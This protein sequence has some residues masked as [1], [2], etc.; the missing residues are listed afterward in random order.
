[1]ARV[2][3]HERT[4]PAGRSTS[5]RWVRK[6]PDAAAIDDAA[7]VACQ[8]AAGA[9][10]P[11]AELGTAVRTVC[12]LLAFDHPGQTVEL[13]VPPFAAVQAGSGDRGAHTRGTPPN[14][15]ETDARTL[16]LLASGTLSWAAA[17]AE[18]RVRAS[19][20][21]SDIGDW[22]GCLPVQPINIVPPVVPYVHDQDD[23]LPPR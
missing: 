8:V 14:V 5:L 13:R 12:A 16:L 6:R 22:F 18:H 23:D 9:D 4:P 3:D 20:V 19:G 15:V 21:H 11:R 17:L 7:A 1:M 10:V 2:L